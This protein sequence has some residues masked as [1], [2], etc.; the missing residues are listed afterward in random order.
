MPALAPGTPATLSSPTAQQ[1]AAPP[2]P[3]RAH[4]SKQQQQQQQGGSSAQMDSQ[5]QLPPALMRPTGPSCHQPEES[6]T[7]RPN[8][9]AFTEYLQ[10]KILERDLH[11]QDLLLTQNRDI[12]PLPP[13]HFHNHPPNAPYR[14]AFPLLHERD[15]SAA[16]NSAYMRWITTTIFTLAGA[17]AALAQAIVEHSERTHRRPCHA[18]HEQGE[19][20]HLADPPENQ[21]TT[22][23]D[24]KEASTP[25]TH[26]Q[27]DP[28]P[29]VHDDD[30]NPKPAVPVEREEDDLLLAT[31]AEHL[32][33]VARTAQ[34]L[35]SL[36]ATHLDTTMA[37][38]HAYPP[39]EEEC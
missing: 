14:P 8:D 2:P 28:I 23:Q 5:S 16:Q 38:Q 6:I 22:I 7:R 30:G 25:G 1:P 4:L 11:S 35:M 29:G 13:P 39:R 37:E 12:V 18:A 27:P 17:T 26:R 9:R 24:S 20:Q 3:W 21:N 10:Q 36:L 31:C 34:Q 19:V 33:H 32:R 15:G